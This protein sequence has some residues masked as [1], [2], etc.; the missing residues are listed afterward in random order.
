MRIICFVIVL[1]FYLRPSAQIVEMAK[2]KY[3]EGTLNSTVIVVLKYSD[4]LNKRIK[5]SFEKYWTVT[6]FVFADKDYKKEV[7]VAGKTYA[8]F[9]GSTARVVERDYSKPVPEDRGTFYA[10]PGFYLVPLDKKNEGDVDLI[11][12]RGPVNSWYYEY[13]WT[14]FNFENCYYRVPYIVKTMNDA[15]AFLKSPEK[16]TEKNYE[17]QV[18]TKSVVLK[19]RTLLVPQELLKEYDVNKAM[20]A[21]MSAGM[22][23]KIA[24]SKKPVMQSIIT[25]AD[26]KAYKGEYKVLPYAEIE[27]LGNSGEASKYA[28]FS[29]IVNDYKF[30]KVYTLDNKELVYIEKDLVSQRVKEKDIKE[31]NSTIGF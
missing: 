5:E 22:G 9:D 10:W 6:P 26:L 17:K 4:S 23:G 20:V 13:S 12:V 15:I 25:E 7:K 27:K 8:V 2:E 30:V 3:Y 18:N 16:K 28:L 24:A 14:S 19:G 31:M 29:P 21:Q 11:C 1:F